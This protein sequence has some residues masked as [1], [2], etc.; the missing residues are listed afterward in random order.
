MLIGIQVMGVVGAPVSM[1]A[2]Y[3][4]LNKLLSHKLKALD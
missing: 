4:I 1:V 3:A 2:I